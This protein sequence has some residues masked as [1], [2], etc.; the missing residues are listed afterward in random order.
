M[1]AIAYGY[2]GEGVALEEEF[3][4]ELELPESF[5]P[6]AADG[7]VQEF[8]LMSTGEVMEALV[9]GNFKENS[10][11]VTVDFLLRKKIIDPRACSSYLRIEQQMNYVDV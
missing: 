4:F 11:V 6:V 1:G 9:G 2:L 10:A 5:E 3:V 8:R 7:E